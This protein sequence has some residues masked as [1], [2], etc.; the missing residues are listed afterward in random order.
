MLQ[1]EIQMKKIALILS[2]IILAGMLSGC[3]MELAAEETVTVETEAAETVPEETI[4]EET[5]APTEETIPESNDFKIVLITR[6]QIDDCWLHMTEGAMKAAR[7]LGCE[8]ISMSAYM[9]KENHQAQQIREAIASGCQAIV[10]S[11]VSGEA[12]SAALAEAAEVG[13]KIVC[14]DASAELM[15]DAFVAADEKTAGKATGEALLVQLKEKGIMNG[16]VGIVGVDAQNAVAVQWEEGFRQA[17][18]GSSYT[19]AETRYSEADAALAHSIVA[20]WLEEQ[21]IAVAACDE[22]AL[23]GAANAV[24]TAENPIPVVG[25]GDTAVIRELID[26]GAILVAVE[27]DHERLGYEGVKVACLLLH[28]REYDAPVL[29]DCSL[30]RGE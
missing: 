15:A 29:A 6:N 13:I 10:I 25:F 2:G 7:E 24:S 28:G 30:V 23:L 3:A 16:T 20:Q 14:M 11:P 21:I 1:K 27:Q 22:G 5:Q 8:V 19:L 18:Q 26:E 17:F 9:E 4:G 12:V